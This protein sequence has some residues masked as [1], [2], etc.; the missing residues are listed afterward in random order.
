MKTFIALLVVICSISYQLHAQVTFTL[1]SSPGV[2]SGPYNLTAADFNGDGKVDLITA[3]R[4]ANTLSVLT[5]NGSGGFVLASSPGVGSNPQGV[6]AADVNG[7]G[8]MDVICANTTGNSLSVLTNNGNGG[9]ATAGTYT[10]GNYPVA[11]TATDVNGDGKVD[12]ISA[13]YSA[14]TISVLTNNGSGG[15]ALATNYN[16]GSVPTGV[17]AMDVNGDGKVD[18]VCGNGG[19]QTLTVLTNNGSGRFALAGTIA[20]GGAISSI[21]TADVNGNGR[22]DLITANNGVNTLTVFTNT[23][24]GGFLL[25]GSYP[26]GHNPNSVTVGDVN[27]D[28]WVDLIAANYETGYGNT[29]S[30]YT[31][32]GSGGFALAATLGVGN[33]ADQVVAA[34]VNGDGRLDLTSVNISDSTVSVLTNS[35]VFPPSSKPI[36]TAQPMDLTNALGSTTSFSVGATATGTEPARQL[37]Y[38]WRL[39]GTNLPSATNSVLLLTNLMLGQAGNYDVV[40]SN[41]VGSVTSNPAMLDVLFIVVKVNGQLASGTATVVGS[42]QVTISG[43]YPNGYFFYTLD[44]STPTTSSMLYIGPINL[45]TSAVVQV[46][47]LSSDFT[48]M[49]YAAPVNIQIIPAF[50]LQA[51]V[52]GNGTLTTNPLSGPY[53]SNSVV[54][55]T[56]HA[57]SHWVFENW[58][59]D[60]SGSQNPLNLTMNG[61]RNVQAVFVRLYPLTLTTPGGGSVTANGQTIPPAT[62]FTNGAVVTLA[63]TPASGWSFL[64]WQG[65][66]GGTNNPLNLVISQTNN[67]QAAFGTVVSTNTSGGGSIVLNQPN[68]VAF[69]TVLTASAVPSPG[70]YFVAWGGAAG[71]PN[72]PT[73]FTVTTPNPNIN[74]LFSTLPGGSYS[75]SVVVMGKGTLAI[76]PQKNYYNA[77]DS[78]TLSASPTNVATGF[79]G[80]TLGASGINDPITVVIS[81]NTVVQANFA[82]AFVTPAAVSLGFSPALTINGTLGY[83]YIIERTANLADPNSWVTVTNIILIQPMQIWVDTSVD[84]SSPFNSIYFYRVSPGSAKSGP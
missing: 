20:G 28:G 13:N 54:T 32:N 9:F 7:D 2:G 17:A 46:M 21:T 40:I 24:S 6:T 68:P 84:A 49:S 38:Q 35:T 74:A 23:G 25:A 58:A 78:V 63:A 61:P 69:G 67:I 62:Y 3:N 39:T 75:L 31:N 8:K 66:V 51:S 33:G 53:P 83:P 36:I 41:Y 44:G 11:V 76:S 64:G 12:L 45:T 72:T 56:A 47:S 1:S 22:V 82:G 16:V 57:A 18:L 71:G 52:I 15:F 19:S 73:T 26:V 14:N 77:G 65:D 81:S 70:N 5:N 59:G 42:A 80:W 29:L 4:D 79:Y 10:V 43:G 27:G 37:S 50:T 34:D 55:L 48:Q 60:A 30:V